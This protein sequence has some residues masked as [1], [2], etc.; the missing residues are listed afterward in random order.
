MTMQMKTMM[1]TTMM[2]MIVMIMMVIIG[3]GVCM[4]VWLA[5]DLDHYDHAVVA[6]VG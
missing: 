3:G 1:T 5:V 6:M 4:C 2:I